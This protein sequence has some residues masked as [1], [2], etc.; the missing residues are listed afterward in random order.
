MTLKKIKQLFPCASQS[1]IDANC[2]LSDAKPERDKASALGSSAS[3]KEKSM[4]RITVRF[5]GHRVRPL[6]PDNFAASIKDLLD[7]LRHLR[8]LPGDEPWLIKL[9]TE[10][11]KVSSF[12]EERTEIELIYP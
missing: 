12:K 1:T 5:T 6:D 3:R 9:E 11:E 8:L 7:G 10:Q 4:E 2:P